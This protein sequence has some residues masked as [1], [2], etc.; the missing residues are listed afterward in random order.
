MLK[1]LLPFGM[2]ASRPKGKSKFSKQN[3]DQGRLSLKD[4]EAMGK[5]DLTGMLNKNMKT[6]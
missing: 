1:M 4:F 2:G 5:N 6:I 3:Y